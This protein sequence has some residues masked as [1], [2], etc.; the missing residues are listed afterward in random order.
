MAEN[1]RLWQEEN[2]DMSNAAMGDSGAG[3]RDAG[4]SGSDLSG[5]LGSIED[6]AEPTDIGGDAAGAA[7]AGAGAATAPTPTG[8]DT[9]F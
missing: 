2:S 9:P 5:D 1:E 6:E 3:M 4:I 8:A 7:A